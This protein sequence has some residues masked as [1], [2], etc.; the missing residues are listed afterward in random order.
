MAELILPE[1]RLAPL[2]LPA[3]DAP[4]IAPAAPP[5]DPAPQLGEV[6]SASQVRTWMDCPARGMF[7]YVYGLPE[8]RNLNLAIGDA[9]H[10]GVLS[11]MAFKVDAGEDLPTGEVLEIVE[12]RCKQ[13]LDEPLH[14]DD[15][16]SP[17]ELLDQAKRLTELYMRDAAPKV[18]P[19]LVEVELSGTIGGVRVRGRLD[20]MD[21]DGVL[22]DLKTG[23]RK[24]AG[25]SGDQRF[26]LATYHHLTP[27]STGAGRV[28]LLVKTKEAQLVQLGH[29]LTPADMLAPE[30]MYP[31]AQALAQSGIYM[32][33]RTSNMCR[34]GSCSYCRECV[35]EFGGQL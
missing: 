22:I 26:Q 13:I 25:V 1:L 32:P 20:L 14:L 12:G 31:R 8:V 18:D 10:E 3:L 4:A 9:V 24:I 7:R 21:T 28:D 30:R 29:T 2:P 11:S 34:P 23:A 27:G 19:L 6:M 16:E 5:A 17:Q 33:N 15:D 35:A